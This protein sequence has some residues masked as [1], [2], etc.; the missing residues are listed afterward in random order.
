MFSLT[1][2]NGTEHR[3]GNSSATD[4]TPRMLEELVGEWRSEPTAKTKGI[5]PS[6]VFVFR[7]DRTYNEF[8]AFSGKGSNYTVQVSG[9]YDLWAV[10]LMAHSW[11]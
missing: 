5:V 10:S 6:V 4:T 3:V 9:T 1:L 8:I 2:P 7:P 11:N